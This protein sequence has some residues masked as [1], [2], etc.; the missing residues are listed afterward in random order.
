M[1]AYDFNLEYPLPT[2]EEVEHSLAQGANRE[3]V[4]AIE[5]GAEMVWDVGDRESEDPSIFL[6]FCVL[7]FLEHMFAFE[8]F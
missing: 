4:K 6:S 7:L 3:M 8:V 1:L 5:D 2:P